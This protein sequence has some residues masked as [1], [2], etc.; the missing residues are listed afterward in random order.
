MDKR[1]GEQHGALTIIARSNKPVNGYLPY[2]W[3]RCQ[4]GN[5]KRLRYDYARK[6]S[7]CGLCEDFKESE[8]LKAVQEY[9]KEE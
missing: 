8:V 7:N 2:Y 6:G 9:G 5:L 1:I 4:C 3:V